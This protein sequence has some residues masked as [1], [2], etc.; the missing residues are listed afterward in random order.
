M[1]TESWQI[2]EMNHIVKI[3]GNVKIMYNQLPKPL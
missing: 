3:K 2:L 1:E